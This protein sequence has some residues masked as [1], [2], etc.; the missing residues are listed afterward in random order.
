MAWGWA[1]GGGIAGNRRNFG[2]TASLINHRDL[3]L[4]MNYEMIKNK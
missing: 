2:E 3:K 4:S 1:T